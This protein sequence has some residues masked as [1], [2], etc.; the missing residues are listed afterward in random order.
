MNKDVKRTIQDLYWK[1]NF[2]IEDIAERLACG[3]STVRRLM[4]KHK[5]KARP[6]GSVSTALCVSKNDMRDLTLEEIA[7]KYGISRSAAFRARKK[8]RIS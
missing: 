2:S 6:R 7:T 5:I 3:Y 8:S 1:E 4:A